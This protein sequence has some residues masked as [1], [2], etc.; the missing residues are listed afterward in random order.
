MAVVLTQTASADFVGSAGQFLEARPGWTL[1]SYTGS[2]GAGYIGIKAGNLLGA[3]FQPT[4]PVPYVYSGA[5]SPTA[6]DQY[7]KLTLQFNQYFAPYFQ[8]P[9]VRLSGAG[10]TF[11]GY[12]WEIHENDASATL[13]TAIL[14]KYSGGAVVATLDTRVITAS[15]GAVAG[16]AIITAGAAGTL[17]CFLGGVELFRVT[18]S[19]P[20]LSGAVG[21]IAYPTSGGPTA[22]AWAGGTAAEVAA[23]TIAPLVT[24][25]GSVGARV[26]VAGTVSVAEGATAIC[27]LTADEPVTFAMGTGGDAAKATVNASGAVAFLAPRDFEAVPA[28]ASAAGTNTYTIP[29][30]ATDPSGNVTTATITVPVLN[31]N[32]APVFVGPTVGN[33]TCTVGT[34][35]TPI[36][37]AASFSDPDAGDSGTYSTVGTWPAGITVSAAGLIS[38]TPTSAAAPT[39]QQVYTG[40]QVQR[41]DAG[42]L[43]ALT[44]AF[45]GTVNPLPATPRTVT[46]LPYSR[47]PGLGSRPLGLTGNTIAVL[48]DAPGLAFITSATAV[49]QAGDGTVSVNSAALPASG[50]SVVMATMEAD[51]T[52]GIG[53]YTVA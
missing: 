47:G 42:G 5:G 24:I 28:N 36:N 23:D 20:V 32:E 45:S 22:S 40:L 12:V 48:Q 30:L 25:P 1:A 3:V 19:T 49:A 7:A 11:A 15:S 44:P 29:V 18:D 50:T 13:R 51:G 41:T 31:V 8:G 52:L 34:A 16:L 2:G 21:L 35:I 46:T 14:K 26:T 39:V 43:T 53:R 37:A 38:G 27:T 9:A 17:A 6:Q 4:G 10:A 33:I